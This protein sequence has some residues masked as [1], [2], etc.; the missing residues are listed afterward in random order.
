MATSD[1]TSEQKTIQIPLNK[2]FATYISAEDA[3]L[4]EIKWTYLSSGYAYRNIHRTRECLPAITVLL[5]RLVLER[6][7]RGRSLQRNEYTDHVNGNKLDN[8]REN[9]RLATPEQNAHNRG[10]QTNN[11][12][13]MKG[14]YWHKK[15][16]KWA[17]Y[18]TINKRY[19][20]LGLHTS[21]NEAAKAYN[22]AA[23]EFFGE[24]ALLNKIEDIHD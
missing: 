7:I 5:H 1:N 18:I 22:E 20:Y 14:V 23:I 6:A 9:L 21:L 8:R 16:G 24:F 13:G 2:G 15:A 19:Q 17:A 12:S 11:T 3:D 10:P 4:A